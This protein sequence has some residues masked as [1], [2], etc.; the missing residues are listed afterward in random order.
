MAPDPGI[1]T[2][3]IKERAR[4]GLLDLLEGVRKAHQTKHIGES[5]LNLIRYEGRR[6]SSLSNH[7][8]VQ[9]VYLSNSPPFKTMEWTKSSCWRT[10]MSMLHRRM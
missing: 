4:K 5:L 8:L 10:T 6:I 3:Q 7:L 2:N 9:S 1:D